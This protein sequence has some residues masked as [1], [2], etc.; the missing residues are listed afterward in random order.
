M[1]PLHPTEA[2]HLREDRPAPRY[3]RPS[4]VWRAGVVALGAAGALGVACGGGGEKAQT[5][6]SL[7]ADAWVETDGAAGRINLDDVRDA[8]QQAY[9][10]NGGGVS[11]FE[12][13]VNEIFEGDNLVLI[14]ADH[15]G[16]QAIISG[17]EDLNGNKRLDENEDDKLFSIVQK[18]EPN[19]QTEVRGHGANSYYHHSGFFD[20]FI[21]GLL[22][23][24][25]FFGGRTQY[26]TLPP[27][28]DQLNSH[29]S[30]YRLGSGYSS[31]RERNATYGS[32]VQSRYGADATARQVSPARSSYQQRQVNSGGFRSSGSTSRSIGSGG[33]TGGTTGGGLSGGGGLMRV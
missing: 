18:L 31:Q 23:G 27:R 9:G 30:S 33:K 6:E 13:R 2:V 7:T 26:V 3:R 14:Q 4:R 11:K 15:Q 16:D 17:W 21:P 29:R 8:Y 5:Q 25:L 22:L 19:G 10:P 32:Q 20:G 1:V 12:E 24:S 28:Y